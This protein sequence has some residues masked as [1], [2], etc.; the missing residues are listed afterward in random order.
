MKKKASKQGKRKA[1]SKKAHLISEADVR[2]LESASEKLLS[3]ISSIRRQIADS[4]L[5]LKQKLVKKIALE[6]ELNSAL[7]KIF[8]D[9]KSIFE[10]TRNA[11]EREA[12]SFKGRIDSLKKITGIYE[13]KKN[14]ILEERK[15]QVFL[16]QQLEK[17][18]R[19]AEGWGSV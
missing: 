12:V 14:R 2:A 13:E 3:E 19:Q 10:K 17:L 1:G 7:E 4:E 8:S 18:S 11:A 5:A 6:D 9:E 15:K 16:R